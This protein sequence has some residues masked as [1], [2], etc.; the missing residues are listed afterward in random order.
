MPEKIPEA[1]CDRDVERKMKL[2]KMGQKQMS[3]HMGFLEHIKRLG[4]ILKVRGNYWRDL[5]TSSDVFEVW[6]MD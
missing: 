3:E 5:S 4:F 1:L 6:G 2:Q